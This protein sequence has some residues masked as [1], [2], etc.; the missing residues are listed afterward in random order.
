MT[1]HADTE[2]QKLMGRIS[3]A[4]Q[5]GVEVPCMTSATPLD[6]ISDD[7]S[8]QARAVAGCAQCPFA[9]KC[10]DY[11]TTFNEPAGIWGGTKPR[12]R[13]NPSVPRRERVEVKTP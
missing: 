6:W 12:E 13:G 5:S 7:A 3:D 11:A 8:A 10:R 2:Y 1:L 4:L 9:P